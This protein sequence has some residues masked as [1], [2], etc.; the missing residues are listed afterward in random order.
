LLRRSAWRARPAH[1]FG[2]PHHDAPARDKLHHRE[3]AGRIRATQRLDRRPG[4]RALGGRIAEEGDA[5]LIESEQRVI[6]G[7]ARSMT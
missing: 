2:P 3:L 1:E 6:Y 5:S 7:Q 4:I